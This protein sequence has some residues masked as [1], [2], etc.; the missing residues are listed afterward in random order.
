VRAPTDQ[1]GAGS[2]RAAVGR[3]HLRAAGLGAAASPSLASGRPRG[4]CHRHVDGSPDAAGWRVAVGHGS[5]RAAQARHDGHGAVRQRAAFHSGGERNFWVQSEP[6]VCVAIQL[7]KPSS[8]RACAAGTAPV[9]FGRA[10]LTTLAGCTLLHAQAWAWPCSPSDLR[11]VWQSVATAGCPRTGR[12]RTLNQ[13]HIAAAST[14]GGKYKLRP[15]GGQPAAAVVQLRRGAPRRTA[16]ESGKI[17][18][19][20]S[21]PNTQNLTPRCTMFCAQTFDKAYTEYSKRVRRWV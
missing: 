15:A 2:A 16:A 3:R 8:R 7:S 13:V 18:R 1:Y 11:C 17:L 4:R 9:A 12:E 20:P 6:D 5:A 21:R 19:L 14:G 10:G